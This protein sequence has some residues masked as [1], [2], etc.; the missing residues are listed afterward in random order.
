MASDLDPG[1][2]FGVYDFSGNPER[3]KVHVTIPK[4]WAE[5]DYTL[6]GAIKQGGF[7]G[8]PT[9]RGVTYAKGTNPSFNAPKTAGILS[10]L[11]EITIPV[12]PATFLSGKLMFQDQNGTAI[13]RKNLTVTLADSAGNTIM[14]AEDGTFQSYAEEYF[15]TVSGAGV[16]YASGSVTMTE[17][18]PNEFTVTLQAVSA[19]A[20]DGTTQTEPQTNDEGVYQ[21]EVGGKRS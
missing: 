16:E 3:Q 11:P 20:W 21:I 2:N 18:G 10:R 14:V 12:E 9:H 6:T 5:T 7:A 13:D 17:E 4:Y 1:G 15:Y 19:D 8:L